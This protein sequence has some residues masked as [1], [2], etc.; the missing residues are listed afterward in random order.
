MNGLDMD[1]KTP[2]YKLMGQP[3]WRLHVQALNLCVNDIITEDEHERFE[4]W[5]NTVLDRMKA[6]EDG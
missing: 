6:E 2:N 3:I 5:L 1:G 4:E